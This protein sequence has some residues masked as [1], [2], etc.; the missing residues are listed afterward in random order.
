M[1]IHIPGY[2]IVRRD[3]NRNGVGVCVYIRSTI[4]F[5]TQTSLISN[6]YEAVVVD[7][8]KPNSQPFSIVAVYRPPGTED[9]LFCYL[10]SVVKAL[11]F[12]NK[13]KIIIGD[14]NCNYLSETRNSDLRQLVA[15]SEVYQLTQIIAQPTRITAASKSLIDLI[16]TNQKSRDVTQGVVDCGISDHSFVYVIRKV[17]V[18]SNNKHKYITTRSFKNFNLDLF[19]KELESLPWENIEYLDSPD[20]MWDVWKRLFTSVADKHA[21]PRTKRVRHKPSPWFTPVLK[22]LI[23]NRNY[24]KRQAVRSG[25]PRDW[26]EYKVVKNRVNNSIRQSK[27]AF[28]HKEIKQNSGNS[29]EIWKTINSLM[30]R[31][32]KNSSI[33]E[34][35]V[36]NVSFTEPT[37]IADQFNKHFTE[38][39]TKLASVL[40]ESDCDYEQYMSKTNTTFRLKKIT[41]KDILEIFKSLSTRKAIGLDNIS[42]RLLKTAGPTIA[43]SLCSIFNKSIETGVVP[44]EWKNAKVFPLYK[45]DEK[46]DPNNYRQISVLPAV[47]KVFERIIYNQLYGYVSSNH[48]LTKHQSGFRSLHSTVTALLDAT[49]EWYLNIDQ[50][51]TNAVVFLDL[52]KAFDTVSHEILLRKLELYGISGLTLNWF[53]SCLSERKQVCVVAE[54]TSQARNIACGVPQGS[55]LGPLLFL[56]YINDLPACL[57]FATARMYMYVDDTS[58]TISSKSTTR[59]HQELNHDLNNIRDW[60]LANSSV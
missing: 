2:D 5:Q 49:N 40:P 18:P 47:A 12:E 38:I 22:K 31:K 24:L 41:A 44:A 15:I 57:K 39:G 34:L 53:R 4:N 29:R 35:K 14:L 36:N 33:N 60:L 55:I 54:S 21:P 58:I 10:E 42:V 52:A 3:I 16:F 6:I 37:V 26:S 19:L 46:S 27:A 17:A 51:N 13:E 28:Y 50:G 32:T 7:I 48:L 43:G 30:S 25:D 8:I 20:T 59:L 45:K 56:I 11:D 23:I 9:E 1:C